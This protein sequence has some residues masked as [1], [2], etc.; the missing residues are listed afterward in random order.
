M[1]SS[2]YP[3]NKIQNRIQSPG[4]S[5]TQNPDDYL[6][7]FQKSEFSSGFRFQKSTRAIV[8]DFVSRIAFPPS[9]IS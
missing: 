2:G 5:W 3:G 4:D 9:V 1:V 7:F 8:L 6:D